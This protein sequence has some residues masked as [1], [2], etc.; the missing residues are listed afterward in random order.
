MPH[1][2]RTWTVQSY[3]PGGANVHPIWP[4]LPWAHS[5][6]Y[7]KRHLNRFIRF[8]T[9]HGRQAPFFAIGRLFP[10]K[11]APSYGDLDPYLTYGYLGPLKSITE[12]A[13]RLITV[14]TDRQ[15]DRLRC[16]DCNN[17]PHIGST[18]MR[19]NNGVFYSARS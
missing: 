19:P 5:S 7:P 3:S 2:R 11:I 8:C 18:A 15:T 13:S 16:S 17:R 14:V 12:T 4:M 1:R 6:P 9:A 10:L